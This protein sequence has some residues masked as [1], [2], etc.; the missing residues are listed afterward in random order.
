VAG[1]GAISRSLANGAVADYGRANDSDTHG[2]RKHQLSWAKAGYD[3]K[4]TASC[5]TW[6]ASADDVG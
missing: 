4:S 2:S 3:G 5:D 6:S 1:T